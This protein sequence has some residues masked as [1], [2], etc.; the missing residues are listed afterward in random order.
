VKGDPQE[1]VVNEYEISDPM[2]PPK[3]HYPAQKADTRFIR[4]NRNSQFNAMEQ[5]QQ[6]DATSQ[7]YVNAGKETRRG[8]TFFRQVD[9]RSSQPEVVGARIVPSGTLDAESGRAEAQEWLQNAMAKE[10]AR[11]EAIEA[12]QG[13]DLAERGLEQDQAL[14]LK[15]PS[16]QGRQS[17]QSSGDKSRA[18]RGRLARRNSTVNMYTPSQVQSPPPRV[19]SRAE[20]GRQARRNDAAGIYTPSGTSTEGY[21]NDFRANSAPPD[22]DTRTPDPFDTYPTQRDLQ[23]RQQAID[24]QFSRPPNSA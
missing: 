17:V 2:D 6:E 3:P 9:R 8:S 19:K 12:V 10:R 4:A 22:A 16:T 15:T 23:E 18:E 13:R 14:R 21:L 7:S 5:Q 1:N 20:R 11:Q 24:G